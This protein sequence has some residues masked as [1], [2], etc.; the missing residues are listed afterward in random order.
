MINEIFEVKNHSSDSDFIILSDEKT[1]KLRAIV[2]MFPNSE[3]EGLGCTNF[4]EH[5]IDT[6]DAKPIKQRY[7]P[8]SPAKE[9]LLC[10]E[11]DRMLSLGVIEECPQS[12]WS[13]PGVLIEKPEKVRFWVDSRK[14]NAVT[15]KKVR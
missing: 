8:I 15:V 1:R 10:A 14:L 6:G 9:K 7:Y 3:K 13:S 11:I 12:A 2:D 4:V 5:N